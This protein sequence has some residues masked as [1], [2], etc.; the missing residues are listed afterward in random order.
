M[1]LNNQSD[2]NEQA[3]LSKVYEDKGERCTGRRQ[4]NT[5]TRPAIC[6]HPCLFTNT[7]EKL[8]AGGNTTDCI[9]W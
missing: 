4:E 9:V 6:A 8:S 3:L 1:A 2:I 5:N 7:I